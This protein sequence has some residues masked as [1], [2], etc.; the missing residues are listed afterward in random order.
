M[1]CPGEG[2]IVLT[3]LVCVLTLTVT[4]K[5]SISVEQHYQLFKDGSLSGTLSYSNGDLMM[6]LDLI[7]RHKS[8]LIYHDTKGFFTILSPFLTG[9]NLS[10]D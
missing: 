10:S 3:L 6:C 1:E 7:Q 8:I 2:R 5:D 4:V 9:Q